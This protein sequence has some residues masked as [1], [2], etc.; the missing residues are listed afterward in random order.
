MEKGS[1]GERLVQRLPLVKRE[2]RRTIGTEVTF[3]EERERERE[4]ET[5][6]YPLLARFVRERLVPS[7]TFLSLGEERA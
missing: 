6:L 3:G 4:R 7:S 5:N 1:K 2:Q